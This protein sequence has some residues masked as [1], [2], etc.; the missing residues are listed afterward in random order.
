[1]SVI[2]TPWTVSLHK[3]WI[4][5]VVL[6]AILVIYLVEKVLDEVREQLRLLVVGRS[7]LIAEVRGREVELVLDFGV[8]RHY[9]IV[10]QPLVERCS[11]RAL[12][13]GSNIGIEDRLGEVFIISA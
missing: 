4:A 7:Q 12:V 9:E 13:N 2:F 3:Y 5:I 8:V 11:D 1:M 10:V 6:L